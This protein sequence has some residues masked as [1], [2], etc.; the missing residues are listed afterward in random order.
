MY[1]LGALDDNGYI[2]K[3]GYEINRFP[4]EPSYSRAVISSVLMGCEEDVLTV[5][6]FFS[7]F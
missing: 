7:K 4:L 6:S 5:Y 2:T 3:F 1:L